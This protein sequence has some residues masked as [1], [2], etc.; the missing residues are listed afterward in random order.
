MNWKA[1][2]FVKGTALY[3]VVPVT[4]LIT[5]VAP[6]V[7]SAHQESNQTGESAKRLA[8][9]GE[10]HLQSLPL[11]KSNLNESR[12]S[13]QLA[14]GVL[15]TTIVRGEQSKRDVYT[16]DVT[17]KAT[18]QEAQTVAES[19][20]AL[21]YQPRV[22]P[23]VQ[24]APDDPD[25]G[26]LGYL[27]RVGT[28]STEALA[29]E[30]RNQLTA[31]GYS[32]LRVVN[33]GED[34]GETTG[35][36]VVNV[37]EVDPALFQG[38]LAPALAT[39]IVPENEPLT[40]L[41]E[42]TKALAAVNGGYFVIGA[43]DGTPG[44]LAGISILNGKLVS[45]A[46][47]GRT[48]LIL[49]SGSGKS[50]RIAALT[51]QVSATA[52]D[53][54]TREVDGLNR[55][56][57]L[58]RGCGGVGGDAPTES[59]KHDYTCTDSSELIQFTSA[60]G[61][62]TEPGEGVEVVLDASGQVIEFHQQR[63]GQI[64]RNGSVLSG[65]GDAAEWLQTHA[66]I[67]GKIDI[68]TSVLADE[69][70]LPIEEGLG[71]INGGPRLLRH[72]KIQITAFSEGFHW[73][74]NPEFYYRFGIRRNP[75]TLAGI[76]ATGKLL[77]VTVDGR[78]PGRSVGASFEESARIMRSLGATDAVNLDGGGSTTITINQQL[79][80]RPSDATGERPIADAIVIQQK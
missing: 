26:P 30:L 45:E 80:N 5:V 37:L 3:L 22:Q 23:I 66:H 39:E 28:F 18:S 40:Q 33:T 34:G 38:E 72:G 51:S 68:Q 8:L 31:D 57:G 20:V 44:D 7:S 6:F 54:A 15:H 11:G 46:V 14:P 35:P 12:V 21:G 17:F 29:T 70:E 24:R 43:T 13:N 55:K 63:G 32:G 52:N 76:T 62:T 74:E 41:A 58:I 60:F 2:L 9:A 59:P 53:G 50:V 56:P 25:S 36:W 47:N 64:P 49:P 48:S 71:V 42:R 65:T 1:R 79:V 75:R 67:G 77:L 19:L 16:V 27:V 61:Q 69:K 4:L 10:R 73:Q 78:Q